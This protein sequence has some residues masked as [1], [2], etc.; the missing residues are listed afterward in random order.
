[1]NVATKRSVDI[2]Y[3]RAQSGAGSLEIDCVECGGCS[4]GRGAGG[5]FEDGRTDPAPRPLDVAHK[6]IGLEARRV[7]REQCWNRRE[8]WALDA[9]LGE[10]ALTTY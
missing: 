4:N 8:L 1:V 5:L 6:R 3:W 9:P 7:M 10:D 2:E